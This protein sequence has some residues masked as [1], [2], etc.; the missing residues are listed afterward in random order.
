MLERILIA[1]SGGQGILLIGRLLARSAMQSVPH[2]TYF[3]AYGAEVR[4][5]TSNCQIVLSSDEI[6]SPV[7]EQYDSMLILNQE[8]ALR[9]LPT[10]TA[11]TRV[12][13]NTALC[14]PVG[15]PHVVSVRA[16]DIA[17]ELGEIRAAN[18]VMLGAY[19]AGKTVVPLTAIE[20][21]IRH[22]LAGKPEALIAMNIE[23]L[24]IGLNA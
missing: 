2:V 15:D 3:P 17:N 14:E 16:T 23:A 24:E 1:G 21:G 6:H 7:P 4:G 11:T 12:I 5:G 22:E 19:L 13:L 10:R 18:F 20:E 9:F 8:S